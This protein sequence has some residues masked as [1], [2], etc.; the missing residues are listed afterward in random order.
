MGSLLCA[1]AAGV[2]TYVAFIRVPR[3]PLPTAGDTR[4]NSRHHHTAVSLTG[5]ILEGYQA[6]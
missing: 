2:H 4:N 3:S 1:R 5:T 6:S